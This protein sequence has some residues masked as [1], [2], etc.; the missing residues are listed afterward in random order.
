[1]ANRKRSSKEE[2]KAN[3]TR[4]ILSLSIGINIRKKGVEEGWCQ[5]HQHYMRA[6]FV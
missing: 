5:F 2:L 4:K 1:V 6:F 3:D